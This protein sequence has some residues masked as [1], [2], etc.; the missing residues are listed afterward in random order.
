MIGKYVVFEG[1]MYNRFVAVEIVGETVHF[2]RV[3]GGRHFD[4]ERKLRKTSH[5]PVGVFDSREAAE[6]TRDAI[7]TNFGAL[8]KRQAAERDAFFKSVR[9][10]TDAGKAFTGSVMT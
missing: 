2:W 1:V 10:A 4:D 9:I 6:T 8:L 3:L 7:N 5:D